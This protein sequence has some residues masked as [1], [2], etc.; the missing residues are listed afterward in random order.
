MAQRGGDAGMAGIGNDGTGEVQGV[1]VAGQDH[2][3]DVRVVQVF[4]RADGAGHGSHGQGPVRNQRVRQPV[5]QGRVNEGFVSLDI[6]HMS[7]GGEGLHRFRQAV[8]AAGMVRRG[9]DRL[10][11]EGHGGVEDAL[12]VRGDGDVVKA[13]AAGNA[14]PYVLDKR[15]SCNEVKRLARKSGGPPA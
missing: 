13:G 11:A 14:F 4:L 15:F 10:G 12:V 1:A 3:D 8:A 9:H 6:D 2:F 5:N 7:G